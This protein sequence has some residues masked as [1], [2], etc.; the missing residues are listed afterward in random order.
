MSYVIEW[1]HCGKT[2]GQVWA[3]HVAVMSLI[4]RIQLFMW[5]IQ[6]SSFSTVGKKA[7]SVS[8]DS[9]KD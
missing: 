1:D 7:K 4:A 3:L 9:T 2:R 5:H 8:S 6:D